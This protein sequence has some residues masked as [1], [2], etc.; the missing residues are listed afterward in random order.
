M[1]PKTRAAARRPP[2][3]TNAR[4]PRRFGAPRHVRYSH[5]WRIRLVAYGARLE[6]GLGLTALGGS[7]PPSSAICDESE[8]RDRQVAL[9]LFT[10]PV[11]SPRVRIASGGSADRARRLCPA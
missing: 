5:R 10:S 9:L 4:R 3:N 11:P 2:A 7:N 8:Q 1:L 6:S